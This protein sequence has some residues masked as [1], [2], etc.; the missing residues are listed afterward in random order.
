RLSRLHWGGGTP[1]LMPPDMMRQVAGAVFDA[2]PLAEGAE[3]SVEIDPNE[4][5][6][7]R[8]DALAEA[9][10]TRASIGVQDFDPEI[11]KTIGREQSFE[12]TAQAI[13]MIRDRGIASLNTD[14]LYGLP[15]QTPQKIADSIQKLMALSP[16]RIALYGYAH[17]PWMAKRQVMIPDDTLPDAQARLRLFEVARDLLVAD[18]YDEIG[19]DH[20]AR[21]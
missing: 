5:D 16:D 13:R 9:G 4:I 2:F 19:I 3:F 21:P 6:E 17:V 12:I 11:Q 15:H 7:P 20:F 18:G 14:I 1:T 8:M 10:L